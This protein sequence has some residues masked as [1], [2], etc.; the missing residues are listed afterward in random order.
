MQVRRREKRRRP[1]RAVKPP[2]SAF[3]ARLEPRPHP[4]TPSHFEL[5]P[6]SIEGLRVAS[7]DA[8]AEGLRKER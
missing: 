4:L 5:R 6:L 7:H 8:Y 2:V 3:I 1:R